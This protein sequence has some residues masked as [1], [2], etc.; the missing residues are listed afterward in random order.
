MSLRDQQDFVRR[1]E[2]HQGMAPQEK[3]ETRYITWSIRHLQGER[4]FT[5]WVS[6]TVNLDS[7]EALREEV[8]AH[9]ALD[10]GY[11]H[12]RFDATELLCLVETQSVECVIVQPMWE[13]H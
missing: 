13:K 2:Q 9:Q 8:T 12:D 1:L 7:M 10:R 11:P 4:W 6:R 3:T 5:S